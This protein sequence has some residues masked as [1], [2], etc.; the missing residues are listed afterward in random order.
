M[1]RADERLQR[2]LMAFPLMADEPRLTVDEIAQR[3]GTNVKVLTK[4]FASLERYDT[5][6]G[7]VDTVQVFIQQGHASMVS[8]HF[9]RPQKLN[10][11]EMLALD[12]G[13]GMLQ[14]ELPVDEQPIIAQT[15][16]TLQALS[17]RRAASGAEGV[18]RELTT[19][20]EGA[21]EPEL[22]S[23]A[24]LHAALEQKHVV[25]LEYQRPN[26]LQAGVRRVRPYALVR[27]EA[28]VYLVA[29]CERAEALR[30]FRLDRVLRA[31]ATRD[32][33]EVPADFSLA[34][35]LEQGRVFS[36]DD[37]VDDTLVVRYSPNVARWIAERTGHTVVE[38]ESLDVSY[39]LADEAW[40]VRHV[41]QYGPE[42]AVVSPN[43]VRERVLAVLDALLT[44]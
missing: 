43:V 37:G 15:R 36:R 38:G 2:L 11:P 13:L 41:L 6:A 12:L 40:A 25:A 33:Y 28:N 21:R 9:K 31:E 5:P 24:V 17:V 23:L 34:Q 44:E 22:A 7:W 4:D 10:R 27:A 19:V 39:P 29:W 18:R 35:V 3:V 42:A 1:I 20:V 14:R 26:E 32:T 8:S 30:V 16:Q